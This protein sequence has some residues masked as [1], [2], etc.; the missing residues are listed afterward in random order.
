M[1]AR[2]AF[3]PPRVDGVGE[4]TRE[5]HSWDVRARLYDAIFAEAR[6]F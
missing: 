3:S 1:A 6:S 4:Y 2:L 5:H